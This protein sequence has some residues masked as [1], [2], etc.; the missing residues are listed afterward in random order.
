MQ[1][2]SVCVSS[3][4][5]AAYNVYKLRVWCACISKQRLFPE[6]DLLGDTKGRCSDRLA[7]ANGYLERANRQRRTGQHECTH[8]S[9]NGGPT[10]DWQRKREAS[11][12][13]HQPSDNRVS[14]R[15]Q[16]RSAPAINTIPVINNNTAAA[17]AAAW[18][19]PPPPSPRFF[20]LCRVP[21][22]APAC[23]DV[24]QGSGAR[25]HGGLDRLSGATLADW[26]LQ[27][28]G[29][30][31]RAR[32]KRGRTPPIEPAIEA[33]VQ[34]RRGGGRGKRGKGATIKRGV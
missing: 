33:K 16:Q 27:W 11:I 24:T 18:A 30:V 21:A 14:H 9:R 34:T 10:K 6:T 29:G 3:E 4:A 17:P 25:G 7:T 32:T 12:A 22:C 26:P 13:G 23:G 2:G 28:V 8:T 1:I 20:F 31:C 15:H 19:G 5:I